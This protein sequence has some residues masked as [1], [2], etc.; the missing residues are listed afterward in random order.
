MVSNPVTSLYWYSF[1]GCCFR[2]CCK[3]NSLRSYKEFFGRCFKHCFN[4][5]KMDY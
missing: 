4:N 5:C 2:Y 3:T 1:L